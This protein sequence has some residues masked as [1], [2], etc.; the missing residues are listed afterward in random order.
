ML[1]FFRNHFGMIVSIII[2]LI[3]SLCMASVA[4]ARAATPESPLTL[5]HVISNWG[6]AFLTIMLVSVLL[7][8]KVWGDKLSATLG[9]KAGTL[10]FGLVSNL[11]PTLFYNTAATLVLVG[12]N[13]G[14]AAPFYWAAVAGD[15]I[16]MFVISYV[17]SIIAERL[18]M[19]VAQKALAAPGAQP[20]EIHV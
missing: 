15:Y 5:E 16:L 9:L 18:G 12:V 13:V 4:T 7:P 1:K 19:L 14:F 20:P 8:S 17:L 11:V 2:A 6:T 3:L 10:P